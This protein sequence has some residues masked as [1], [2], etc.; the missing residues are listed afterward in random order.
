LAGTVNIFSAYCKEAEYFSSIR[1][2]PGNER[3]KSMP[4]WI[5]S[6]VLSFAVFVGLVIATAAFGGQW[7]ADPWYKMLSKPRWTPPNW[8]FPIAW[9]IIYLA[10]AVAG[11]TVWDTGEPEWPALMALWAAQLIANAIWSYIF[12]GRKEIGLALADIALLWVLIAAFIVL[13]WD[14]NRLAGLLFLPYLLWVSYAG[15]LNLA[16]WRRNPV[17]SSQGAMP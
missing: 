11:W 1:W 13:A 14:G 5:S 4:D 6:S 8:L 15:A 7:G 2:P 12:F 17:R 16:I 9:T 10:I 3:R